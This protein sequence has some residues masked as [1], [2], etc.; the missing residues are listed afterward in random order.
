MGH[1]APIYLLKEA[2]AD[3]AE[4]AQS[5]A[6]GLGAQSAATYRKRDR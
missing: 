6:S 4:V 5:T 1:I 3:G 2:G